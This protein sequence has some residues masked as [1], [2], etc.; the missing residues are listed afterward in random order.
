MQWRRQVLQVEGTNIWGPV[1]GGT[2][3]PERGRPQY[4]GLGAKIFQKST[5][6]SRIFRHFLQ[7][8]MVSSAVAAMH[9]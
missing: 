2:E 4:G 6:K 3:G 8:E 5:L 7:A 1:D 9:D